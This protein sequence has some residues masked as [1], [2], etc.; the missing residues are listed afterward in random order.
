MCVIGFASITVGDLRFETAD[1][2]TTG[3]GS[4]GIFA[5]DFDGDLDIDLAVANRASDSVTIL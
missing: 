3:G 1:E 2:Y 5:A 4:T